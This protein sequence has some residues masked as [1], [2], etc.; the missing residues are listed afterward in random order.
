MNPDT[1]ML[2]ERA[3]LHQLARQEARRLRDASF[4]AAFAALGRTLQ[5]LLPAGRATGNQ[6][7]RS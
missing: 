3:R 7:C 5:R 4:D 1:L 2:A 6:P